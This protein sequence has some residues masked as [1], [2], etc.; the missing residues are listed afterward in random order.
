[1][2][3]YQFKCRKCPNELEMIRWTFPDPPMCCGELMALQFGTPAIRMGYPL[4]VD[5]MDDIQRRETQ[6]G[7]R[8]RLPHPKEVGA[9]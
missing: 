3:L 1:M 5:R 2:P 9:T 8:M 6:N 7:G 4:W